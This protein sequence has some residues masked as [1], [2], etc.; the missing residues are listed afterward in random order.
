[1]T[2]ALSVGCHRLLREPGVTAVTTAA[3]VVEEIGRIGIDLVEPS[4]PRERPTDSLHHT[5]ARVYDVM[6]QRSPSEVRPLGVE[7]GLPVEVVRAALGELQRAGLVERTPN[8]WRRA[9][10]GPAHAGKA[11]EGRG[12]A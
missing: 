3:E 11:A 7:S 4:A 2:S 8:G 12:G 1:V 9:S 6:D 5:T 10:A